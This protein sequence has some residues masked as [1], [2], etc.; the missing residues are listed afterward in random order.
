MRGNFLFWSGLDLVEGQSWG[1]GDEGRHCF[2]FAAQP[3]ILRIPQG[4][5]AYFSQTD[6]FEYTERSG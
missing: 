6:L 2:N 5:M 1:D 4:E 3:S